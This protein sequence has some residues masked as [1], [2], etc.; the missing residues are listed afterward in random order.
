MLDDRIVLEA[1]VG[2]LRVVHLE[3]HQP[4]AVDVDVVVKLRVLE[5]A[6]LPRHARH[7]EEPAALI[8][9]VVVDLHP[10][11]SRAGPHGDL[12]GAAVTRALGPLR[13]V[14]AAHE[15]VVRHLV[16][17]TMDE[18][19]VPPTHGV[20]IHRPELC[21]HGGGHVVEVVV[22]HQGALTVEH[23]T[24]VAVRYL[25]VEDLAPAADAHADPLHQARHGAVPL[26]ALQVQAVD[27][28]TAAIGRHERPAIRRMGH[29]EP[30]QVA[31]VA[32]I[33]VRDDALGDAHSL[34]EDAA[35]LVADLRAPRGNSCLRR[36]GRG[37]GEAIVAVVARL[38]VHVALGMSLRRQHQREDRPR[39]TH[40]KSP[41]H[42]LRSSRFSRFSRC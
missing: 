38:A 16:V 20:R 17:R 22:L 11:H 19:A 27:D 25:R 41:A 2:H 13:D 6:C 12:R 35:P 32:V 42:H 1:D 18:D 33:R 21:I 7:L 23:H 36:D 15:A 4:S 14:C 26:R 3:Q 30:R 40:K 9:V 37:F 5:A 28:D 29:D 31:S 34:V 24:N 39:P 10:R 8:G